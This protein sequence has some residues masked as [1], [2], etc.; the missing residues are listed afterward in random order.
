MSQ[1]PY[2]PLRAGRLLSQSRVACTG[3]GSTQAEVSGKLKFSSRAHST[4]LM[5]TQVGDGPEHQVRLVTELAERAVAVEAEQTAYPLRRVV[6]VDMDG[7]RLTAAPAHATLL[8]EH[9]VEVLCGD[10]VAMPKVVVTHRSVILPPVL[11]DDQ[12]V[13]GLAVRASTA[14]CAAIARELGNGLHIAALGAP[15]GTFRHRCRRIAMPR[16]RRTFALPPTRG[17]SC[18]AAL[19]TGEGQPV[20][21]ASVAGEGRDRQIQS[22][23]ATELRRDGIGYF[24]SLP[25][26]L[27]E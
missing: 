14:R 12:V 9:L 16:P 1:R 3:R 15:F 21:T 13:A 5:R 18:V 27:D 17:V 26:F 8:G 10:A 20:V 24:G 25:S 7:R 19:G 2:R 4:R 23:V 11:D 6:V 22:T